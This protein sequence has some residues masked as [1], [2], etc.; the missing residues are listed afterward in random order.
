MLAWSCYPAFS[1][2]LQV[3]FLASVRLGKGRADILHDCTATKKRY[4]SRLRVLVLATV[5]AGGGQSFPS[6][7]PWV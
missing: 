2:Q 3:G 4:K 7:C 1:K 5:N 6:G